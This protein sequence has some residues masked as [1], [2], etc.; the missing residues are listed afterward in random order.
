M[1]RSRTLRRSRKKCGAGSLTRPSFGGLENCHF[2]RLRR[3]GGHAAAGAVKPH[4]QFDRCV[5]HPN[6]SVIPSVSRGIWAGGRR[7]EEQSTH[8]PLRPGPST[9]ARD[10][11]ISPLR[12]DRFA[13]M[14]GPNSCVRQSRTSHAGGADT[15]VCAK[16]TPGRR[17]RHP[18]AAPSPLR[19][20]GKGR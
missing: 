17:A 20:R 14:N 15:P 8:H 9:H 6:S 1:R 10:D 12:G 3:C 13:A 2:L 5:E 11:G 18:P 19:V 7:R 16:H 4:M